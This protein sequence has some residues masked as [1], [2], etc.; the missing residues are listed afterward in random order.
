MLPRPCMPPSS[1]P[2]CRSASSV[3]NTRRGT[4]KAQTVLSRPWMRQPV[5]MRRRV[6]GHR[7]LKEHAY[8]IR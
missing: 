4:G 2:P 8:G 3:E 1:P 5:S 6:L 7:S